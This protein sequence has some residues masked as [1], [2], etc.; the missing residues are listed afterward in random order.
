MC[1]LNPSGHMVWKTDDF[2]EGFSLKGMVFTSK[3]SIKLCYV[4]TYKKF[5]FSLKHVY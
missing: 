1:K 5:P 2:S 3:S 4:L